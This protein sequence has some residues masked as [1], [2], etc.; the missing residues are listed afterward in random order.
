MLATKCLTPSG[1]ASVRPTS[2]AKKPVD[3]RAL[4]QTFFASWG[5][6]RRI[7]ASSVDLSKIISTGS[8]VTEMSSR[9]R[10]TTL[11]SDA[12]DQRAITQKIQQMRAHPSVEKICCLPFFFH[13]DF[14]C[15]GQ[16]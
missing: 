13:G 11:I 14:I 9:S 1:V 10:A 16:D 3:M 7:R 6:C 4:G 5:P 8:N 15:N 12:K 2:Q